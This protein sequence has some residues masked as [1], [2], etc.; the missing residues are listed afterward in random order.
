MTR[1]P[2]AWSKDAPNLFQMELLSDP[3]MAIIWGIV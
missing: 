1:K 2:T 3:N